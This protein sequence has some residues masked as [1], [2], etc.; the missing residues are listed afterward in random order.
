MEDKRFIPLLRNSIRNN[1]N[2]PALSDYNDEPFYYYKDVARE[3]VKLHML[4]DAMNLQKGDRVAICGRNSS[5]WAITF[6]ATM[7]YGAIPTSILHDFSGENIQNI[8]NHS[9]ARILVAAEQVW[10]K[11][12]PMMMPA[13]ETILLMEDF[14]IQKANSAELIQIRSEWKTILNEK[15]PQGLTADD[16]Y[17]HEE[18]ADDLVVLNYTSGTTST[19]K[20][21]M[22]PSRSLWSNIQLTF[23]RMPF[24][25]P[26]DSIVSMLPMAHMYGLTVEILMGFSM[27]CHVHFL[28]RIPSP[29]VILE[30]FAK[31][32]PIVAISVPLII[33]KIVQSK[34]FPELKKQP[35]KFLLSMSFTRK[36]VLKKI[37]EKLLPLFGTNLNQVIIG[38]AALNKEVG[39]FLTEIGFPYTVGYGMTECGPLITFISWEKFKPESCGQIVDRMEAKVDSPDPEN[40]EG[41]LIVRGDNTML[42]YF[43]NQEQTDAI[44]TEDGWLHTGD[45]V[46]MDKDNFVFIKGRCKSVILGPSGQNIYPEEIE[47]LLNNSPYVAEALIIE[48]NR[49]LIALIY[50]DKEYLE[51]QNTKEKNI[52]SVFAS[53][54]KSVNKRLPDFSRIANFRLQKEEFEKTPKRSIKRFLY[55]R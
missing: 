43:K 46:T 48:E 15:Y 45:L 1:W 55:Q 2:L 10:T 7:T 35:A 54:I 37:K 9:E 44:M 31:Y 19:P 21:V 29:Q 27:G 52:H 47:D 28:P 25:K 42:G 53:E 32:N 3:I 12:D 8:V 6:F 33:E 17:F 36:R 20:G 39:R 22:L 24:I 40:V 13:V 50:P 11:V 30:A 38:G 26:G 49:K 14:S 41:E 4:F 23:D 34:V 5:H 16:V 51:K 18:K